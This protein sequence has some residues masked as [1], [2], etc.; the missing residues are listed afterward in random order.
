M[1]L[2]SFL[3]I[4]DGRAVNRSPFVSRADHPTGTPFF[5]LGRSLASRTF[6]GG[7]VL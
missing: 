5:F 6:S 1:G 7:K 3:V 4:P 2:S